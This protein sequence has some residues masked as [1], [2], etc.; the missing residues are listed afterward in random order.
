MKET[1]LP[2]RNV[3]IQAYQFQTTHSC[4]PV[5]ALQSLRLTHSLFLFSGHGPFLTIINGENRNILSCQRVFTTSHIHGI[6]CDSSPTHAGPNLLLI[7]GGSSLCFAKLKYEERG[8]STLQPYS[9]Q[10][11]N[12]IV[13]GLEIGGTTHVSDWILDASFACDAS[14]SEVQVSLVTA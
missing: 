6:T 3:P 5:T 9:R 2:L 1:S 12:L 13:K 14:S 7:W 8:P 10:D 4:L 11:Q